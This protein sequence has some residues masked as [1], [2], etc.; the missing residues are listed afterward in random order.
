MKPDKVKLVMRSE[1]RSL[2]EI[3]LHEGRNRIVRRMMDSVAHPVRKLS[4]TAIGPV[5]LGQLP[6]GEARELTRDEMGVL[7]DLVKM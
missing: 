5:R 3:T 7:L 1:T 4:R 2:V 6:I